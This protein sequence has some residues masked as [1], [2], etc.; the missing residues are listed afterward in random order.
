MSSFG[1][2]AEVQGNSLYFPPLDMTLYFERQYT[3]QTTTCISVT[4][5][6]P[7]LIPSGLTELAFGSGNTEQERDELAANR[8]MSIDF[9]VFHAY[10]CKPGNELNVTRMEMVSQTGD[11]QVGWNILLGEPEVFSD[12]AADNKVD[13]H[14]LL[15]LIFNTIA[16]VLH[17]ERLFAIKLFVSRS[18]D[19][20]LTD[21][22][23]NG[24]GWEPASADL[25]RYA[26]EMS[27]SGSLKWVKQ[28]IIVYPR[29][30]NELKNA[31]GLLDG[32][33]EKHK[34]LF[35]NQKPQDSS[36]QEEKKK[37]W[38]KFW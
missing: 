27:L 16:G 4:V 17:D 26:A 22:R 18:G 3:K 1:Y 38:Y 11:K 10:L 37:S 21:A 34:E 5:T 35:G 28:F 30:F 6:H 15:K 33:N 29:S 7:I 36:K 2:Q 13:K 25:R 14:E 9:P 20:I 32:L 31:D 23:L 12:K 19:D 24:L 8:W